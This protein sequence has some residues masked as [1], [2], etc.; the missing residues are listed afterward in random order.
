MW[1]CFNCCCRVRLIVCAVTFLA[2][3]NHIFISNCFALTLTQMIEPSI[4]VTSTSADNENDS[5][6]NVE[7]DM[8][9]NDW[10]VLNG[11]T[12]LPS[13]PSQSNKSFV[14]DVFGVSGVRYDWHPNT[15]AVILSAFF[16]G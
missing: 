13:N 8:R 9:E 7:V 6:G 3:V 4:G 10:L 12:C 15:K 16:A 5:N 2:A 11:E 1:Q 14:P